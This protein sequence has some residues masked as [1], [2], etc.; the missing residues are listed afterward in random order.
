[1]KLGG[2]HTTDLA[3]LVWL[4]ATLWLALSCG[5]FWFASRGM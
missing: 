5:A 4:C 1:M 2:T 3:T